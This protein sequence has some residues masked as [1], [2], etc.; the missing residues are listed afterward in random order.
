MD[1]AVVKFFFTR[2]A[3]ELLKKNPNG[4]FLQDFTK[5]LLCHLMKWPTFTMMVN[6]FIHQQK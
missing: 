6:I 3:D 2:A 4:S 5:A 1:Q